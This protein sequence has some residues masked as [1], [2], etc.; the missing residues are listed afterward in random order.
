MKEEKRK[1][2]EFG[3]FKIVNVAK[4]YIHAE[5]LGSVKNY[6]AQIIKNAVFSDASV[7]ST[8][9]L[10]VND[11]STVTNYGTDLKFEPVEVLTNPQEIEKYI[12][13]DRKRVAEIYLKG[14]KENLDKG[15]FS[16]DA[17]EKA[18]LFSASQPTLKQD[19]LDMRRRRLENMILHCQ[20]IEPKTSNYY[21]DTCYAVLKIFRDE[22]EL[23]ELNLEGFKESIK[24]FYTHIK[25]ADLQAMKE[26]KEK[27]QQLEDYVMQLRGL[28]K[29]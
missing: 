3:Q 22:A 11:Q 1:S 23:G 29:K 21:T 16:G 9:Y 24:A 20:D 14:A 8:V 27:K 19:N 2:T 5:L 7:G 18:I 17:I 6:K 12:L 10:R 15:W 13:E 26:R 25:S 28:V 4:K